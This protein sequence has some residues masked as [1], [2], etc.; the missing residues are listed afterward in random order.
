MLF[1]KEVSFVEIKVLGTGCKKCKVLEQNVKLA[2]LEMN[3]DATVQKV[4]DIKEIMKYKVMS[5]PALV[6]SNKVVSTGK[7]LSVNE[8]KKLLC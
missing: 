1:Y 3:I 8:V 5:T 6:M 2:L 4:E 7:L